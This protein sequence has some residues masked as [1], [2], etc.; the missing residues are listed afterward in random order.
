[1][2]ILLALVLAIA[3]GWPTSSVFAAEPE[4]YKTESGPNRVRVAK[5]SWR[6]AARDRV[7]PVK[8]YAPRA[9][10][11]ALP[12]ILVSHGVGGSRDALE[13]LGRHWASHGYLSVHLQHAGSDINIWQGKPQAVARRALQEAASS[14]EA[15]FN[16]PQDVR[17][18]IDHLLAA[19]LRLSAKS[20]NIDPARIAVA[21]HSYGAFT[22]LASAGIA[23]NPFGVSKANFGDDRLVASIAMSAGAFRAQGDEAFDSV[24]IPTLHMTGTED[25]GVVADTRVEERRNAYD[26]IRNAPKYL[27]ILDGG[28][29]MIFGGPRRGAAKRTDRRHLAII[30]STTTAFLDSFVNGDASATE[31][32]A[33]QLPSIG[34]G[35]ALSEQAVPN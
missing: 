25:H 4:L 9:P 6:D 13:Y 29:H 1:M 26:R 2:K 22:A 35:V 21:G 16:R 11:T 20:V 18:A 17:F 27:V 12:V 34:E 24:T 33:N 30:K 8:I 15:A 19:P 7:V 23:F 10:E 14:R 31:W 3:V 5:A 32:L 28:D